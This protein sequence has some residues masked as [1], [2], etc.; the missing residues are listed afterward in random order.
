MMFNLL[1]GEGLLQPISVPEIV[2]SFLC[3]LLKIISKLCS[4]TTKLTLCISQVLVMIIF[5]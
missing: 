1:T 4:I 3:T 5:Y 2:C